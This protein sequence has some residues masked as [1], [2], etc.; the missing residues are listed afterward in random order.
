MSQCIPVEIW[1]EI[2]KHDYDVY[3]TLRELNSTWNREISKM[4]IKGR[5]DCVYTLKARFEP[6]P[7]DKIDWFRKF[8]IIDKFT[9]T[10]HVYWGNERCN[11]YGQHRHDDPNVHDISFISRAIFIVNRYRYEYVGMDTQGVITYYSRHLKIENVEICD[12]SFTPTMRK[13]KRIDDTGINGIDVPPGQ[14][15]EYVVNDVFY[16]YNPVSKVDVPIA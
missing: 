15:P 8:T 3:R 7:R 13:F 2:S 5:F 16:L 4:N 11:T 12:E 1:C 9:G 6:H 10:V 14:R